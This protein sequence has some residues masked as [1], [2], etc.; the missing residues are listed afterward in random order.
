VFR[1]V[2]ASLVGSALLAAGPAIQSA[3]VTPTSGVV[4][5]PATVLFTAA[6]KDPQAVPVSVNLQRASAD[7]TYTN[8]SRLY[9]DGTNGD[10]KA[11]DGVY[12][13][14]M[15]ISEKATGVIVFRVSA[16]V[17]GSLSRMFSDPM[18]F[19]ITSGRS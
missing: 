13:V 16:A 8:V 2:A 3:A 9:D 15:T 12:S 14:S 18:N 10:A 17:R 19:N 6:I 1:G 4:H 7:G 5:S 11:G